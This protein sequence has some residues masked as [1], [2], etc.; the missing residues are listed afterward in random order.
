MCK[1]LGWALRE[2]DKRDQVTVQRGLSINPNIIPFSNMHALHAL[3]PII[4]QS[5]EVNII[6]PILQMPKV[7]LK[8]IRSH[9]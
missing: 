4:P 7:G 5:C 2:M 3:P 9:A 8:Q 6:I 1:A